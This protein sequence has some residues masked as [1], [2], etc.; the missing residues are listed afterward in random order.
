[1]KTKLLIPPLLVATMAAVGCESLA[2]ADVE[3]GTSA[4]VAHTLNDYAYRTFPAAEA[5]IQ[6]A[7][8]VALQR[9]NIKVAAAR[10]TNGGEIIQAKAKNR[11]IE[12]ELEAL[13]P[14]TTRMR[15]VARNGFLND[16]TTALEIIAQ[17]ER[18]LGDT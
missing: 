4:G 8:L 11:A 17:T 14:N 3:V 12:V 10:K 18:L 1:M 16:R 15:A 6:I 9:M 2:T 5:R 13:S 7:T